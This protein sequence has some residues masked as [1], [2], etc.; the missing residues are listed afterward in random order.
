[1][2]D[3]PETPGS[4]GP[5]VKARG[6]RGSTA[7]L[8]SRFR[9]VGNENPTSATASHRSARVS[10]SQH[11]VRSRHISTRNS[12]DSPD[13][14]DAFPPGYLRPGGKGPGPEE[15]PPDEGLPIEVAQ[16]GGVGVAEPEP[17]PGRAVDSRGLPSARHP[18]EGGDSGLPRGPSGRHDHLDRLLTVGS[19]PAPAGDPDREDPHPNGRNR[20]D[21]PVR[22]LVHSGSQM[23]QCT[24]RIGVRHG[25]PDLGRVSVVDEHLLHHQVE[26]VLFLWGR[27]RGED[28]VEAPEEGGD[29]GLVEPGQGKPV[30]P[31]AQLWKRSLQSAGFCASR[32]R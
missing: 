17:A 24:N 27:P 8:R 30:A 32:A 31:V 10:G 22:T 25:V 5:G 28:I 11:Q 3:L 16:V 26:E 7:I 1:M 14:G 15:R 2:P 6:D 13:P 9:R 29:L 23:C 21:H 4:H 12:I 19:R 18:H 20:P